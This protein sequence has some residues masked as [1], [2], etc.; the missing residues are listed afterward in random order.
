MKNLF[1]WLLR[2]L[3]LPFLIIALP[4]LLISEI[5]EKISGD[6]IDDSENH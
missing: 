5:I 4:Y 2:I 3:T 1:L 6:E